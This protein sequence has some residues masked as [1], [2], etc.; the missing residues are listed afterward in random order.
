MSGN[1]FGIHV[2]GVHFNQRMVSTIGGED[3]IILKKIKK[4]LDFNV[5]LFVHLGIENE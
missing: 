2:V 4:R 3:K 5:F 1:V